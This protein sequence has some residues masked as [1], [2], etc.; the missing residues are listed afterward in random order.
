MLDEA[1]KDG[2]DIDLFVVTVHKYF[3]RLFASTHCAKYVVSMMTGDFF[4]K[5]HCYS[6]AERIICS[7]AV[8]TRKPRNGKSIYTVRWLGC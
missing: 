5:W 1:E 8:F 2:G 3:S 7:K 6:P 4:V